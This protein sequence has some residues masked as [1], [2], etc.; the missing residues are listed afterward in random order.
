MRHTPAEV[1]LIE[2]MAKEQ[3]RYETMFSAQAELHRT[4]PLN[5]EA[6][7]A[8]IQQSPL[9]AKPGQCWE[10]A[11]D[12]VDKYLAQCNDICQSVPQNFDE[13]SLLESV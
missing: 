1:E 5:F 12:S 4:D 6:A 9:V 8:R 3:F 7:L 2:Y 10:P 13:L 11:P